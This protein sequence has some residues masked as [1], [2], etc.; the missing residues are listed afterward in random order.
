MTF[1]LISAVIF[2]TITILVP[3]KIKRSEI[4][5]VA[6]FS[7]VLGFTTDITLDL[8]YNWY[9]YFEPGVQ[10]PGFLPI[11]FHF[12][13]TGILFINFFP[14]KRN[15]IQRIF[16]ITFW[17]MFCLTFEYLSIKSG[18]FYHNEWKFSY[19][20]LVYPFLFWLHLLHFNFYKKY[21][22]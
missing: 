17:T 21:T 22:G 14:F 9:G 19:S 5:A 16:Y 12:P 13:T 1:L 10:Y 7:I 15:L 2:I 18:Y 11:L 20:A 4:Y 8:K 6:L 3:K